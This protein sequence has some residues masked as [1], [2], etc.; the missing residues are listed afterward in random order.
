MYG[1]YDRGQAMLENVLRDA[2]LV[3][4]L[5]EV[6]HQKWVPMIEGI[7]EILAQGWGSSELELRASLTVALDFFTWKTLATS[8]LSNKQAARLA[9]AWVEAL[10]RP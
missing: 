10:P 8:G 5:K 1:Y 2:T 4:A 9:T 7:V 6:L 3:P